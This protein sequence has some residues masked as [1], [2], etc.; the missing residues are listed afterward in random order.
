MDA[1][2]VSPPGG[3]LDQLRAVQYVDELIKDARAFLDAFPRTGATAFRS[4][5]EAFVAQCVRAV[6]RL[7]VD[8]TF[9][10]AVITIDE[11]HKSL[12]ALV[13]RAKQIRDGLLT[14]KAQSEAIVDYSPSEWA[15]QQRY[16]YLQYVGVLATH[17]SGKFVRPFFKDTLG[18][19]VPA[20]PT[21]RLVHAAKIY[22]HDVYD[23]VRVIAPA[24]EADMPALYDAYRTL[25]DA[26]AAGDI[27][28]AAEYVALTTAINRLA[29]A[30]DQQI[31]TPTGTRRIY[32][33]EYTEVMRSGRILAHLTPRVLAQLHGT[34]STQYEKLKLFA[35]DITDMRIIVVPPSAYA[36]A[37][38]SA[39][40]AA[41]A[42][43][44]PAAAP[45]PTTGSGGGW[46]SWLPSFMRPIGGE[47]VQC[48][49]E[50]THIGEESG[51][52]YCGEQCMVVYRSAAARQS[53]K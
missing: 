16:R 51:K 40:P 6:A 14:P 29:E 4:D 39:K 42:S 1:R 19:S 15:Y 2:D 46:Q 23:T 36:A 24:V 9:L 35:E 41:A 20:L 34:Q 53:K 27:S 12:A 43:A 33:G 52:L 25:L 28:T 48:G 5:V 49:A 32:L 45:P 3:V 30:V 21:Q 44:K 31:P 17:E 22:A 7:T 37:A 26:T 38:A 8:Q 13:D 50:A 10:R 18:T 11:L 47:C